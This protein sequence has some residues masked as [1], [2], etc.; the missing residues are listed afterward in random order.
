MNLSEAYD[1]ALSYAPYE[2]PIRTNVSSNASPASQPRKTTSQSQRKCFHCKQAGHLIAKCPIL[3]SQQSAHN[4][5]T[6]RQSRQMYHMETVDQ[7]YEEFLAW[8][9]QKAAEAA[10]KASNQ[11][12]NENCQ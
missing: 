4:K 5:G 8:K 7:E 2:I 6:A 3:K 10:A 12:G 1:L 9:E 11:S